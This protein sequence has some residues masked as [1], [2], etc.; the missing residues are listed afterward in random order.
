MSNPPDGSG[1]EVTVEV[2]VEQVTVQGDAEVEVEQVTVQG[3]AEVEVEQVTVQGDAGVEVEQVTVRS[4][5][6][7]WAKNVSRLQ[8]SEVPSGAVNRNVAGRR[9]TSPIQGFGR[10][11]QKTYSVKLGKAA[12]ASEVIAEWR[13][14]FSE[15]WP[16]GNRFY[17]PLTGIAPG[18]VAVLNLAMPGGMKLSTGVLVLYADEESFTLMTPEGHMLA[19]WI[20][21][22]AFETEEGTTAQ[23]QVLMRAN[24]PFFEVALTFGG[25]KKEDR[26]W[27]HTLSALAQHFGVTAEVETQTV[28]VDKSRRWTNAKN[29]RYN[30][31]I[32][33]GLY[34]SAAP[35]RWIAKPFKG[36]GRRD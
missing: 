21:F 4:D 12:S 2:E 26:F 36:S 7:N 25:H 14:H 9:L 34:A 32:R 23:A 13:Q 11:W 31:A 27:H 8:V 30:S 18:D 28:C 20:T 6:E 1:P 33:S 16:H 19:G 29:I 10:M 17:G 3:D 15:F 5:A 22:S 24:D 35:I